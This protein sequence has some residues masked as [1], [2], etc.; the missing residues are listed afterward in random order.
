MSNDKKSEDVLMDTPLNPEFT[1]NDRR[2]D[3]SQVYVPGESLEE[4]HAVE[5]GNG[6]IAEKVIG[7]ANENG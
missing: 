5:E 4:H 3:P 2:R 6:V 7:Q 1:M